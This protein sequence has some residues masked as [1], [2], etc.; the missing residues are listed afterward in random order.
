LKI[1]K[2][3]FPNISEEQ[4][5]QFKL[6]AEKFA[7][8]NLQ[9]NMISRKDVENLEERHILHSLAIARLISFK[10]Q[11]RILDIGTGGGFPGLPLAIMF[12]DCKFYLVD[13]IGKK[14]KIV[15]QLI[16]DLGLKNVEAINARAETL[17]IQVDFVV[18]R[19]VAPLSDLYKWG[20]KLIARDKYNDLTNG[21][22]LLKGG[23]LTEEK[24][25][26]KIMMPK[27]VKIREIPLDTYFKE[28]FFETKKIIYVPI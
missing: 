21:F 22:V 8:Y 17:T 10:A 4:N 5:R 13:S 25:E 7:E 11:T 6:L 20:R 3:Y 19:A 14:I 27:G 9:V 15:S 1:I 18:S 2:K 23:N 24:N 28:P 12:P 16:D 26:F